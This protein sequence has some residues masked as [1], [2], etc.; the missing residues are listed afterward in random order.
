MYGAAFLLLVFL[1]ELSGLI[2]VHTIAHRNDGIEVINQR[3]IVFTIGGSYWNF[4]NNCLFFQFSY[5]D[6]QP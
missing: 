5:G 1:T 2:A 4:S 6:N 3:I